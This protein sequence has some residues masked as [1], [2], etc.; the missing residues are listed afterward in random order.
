LGTLLDGVI[1]EE[2]QAGIAIEQE[3]KLSAGNTNSDGGLLEITASAVIDTFLP[4]A[5]LFIGAALAAR[6]TTPTSAKER[7]SISA[8]KKHRRNP[9][10]NSGKIKLTEMSLTSSIKG[11]KLDSKK[12]HA[13]R[14]LKSLLDKLLGVK[15]KKKK[16]KSVKKNNI[17]P[18]SP[19]SP[20]N[21]A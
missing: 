9:F 11:L 19:I 7:N 21:N 15:K 17:A 1:A 12:L 16:L 5:S 3:T 18:N 20:M 2:Q 6:A 10:I 8:D 13:K 14:S 4:G